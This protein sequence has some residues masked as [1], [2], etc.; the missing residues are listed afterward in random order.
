MAVSLVH[1]GEHNVAD[2]MA[3]WVLAVL[4]LM[5]ANRWESWRERRPGRALVS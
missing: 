1:L 4:V 2:L 3:G 5:G